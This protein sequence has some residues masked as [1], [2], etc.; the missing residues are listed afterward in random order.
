MY[1]ATAVFERFLPRTALRRFQRGVGNPSGVLM[2]RLPGWAVVETTG[3]RS[4][5]VSH[6]PVG[7]RVIGDSLWLV[8]VDPAHAGY[9]R[10]ITADPRV[11]VKIRGQWRNGVASFRDDLGTRKQMLRVNPI[12]G[13]YIALAG[14][15][16]RTIQ[17]RLRR[18]D[19]EG[20][21]V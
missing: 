6:V 5:L 19:E 4:G 13:L 8:A 17:V 2:S 21:I 14:R 7:G 12:N 11:R 10:N 9:V 1:Y 15:E 3:R 16:H 18:Y 20:T